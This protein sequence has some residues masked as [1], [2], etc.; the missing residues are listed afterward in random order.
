LCRRDESVRAVVVAVLVL[1]QAVNLRSFYQRSSRLLARWLS[2]RF[3][4]R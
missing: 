3:R 2:A 4:E 1:V